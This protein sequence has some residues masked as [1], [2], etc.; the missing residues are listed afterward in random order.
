MEFNRSMMTVDEAGICS[1]DEI[2][3]RFSDD[4][5]FSINLPSHVAS[6]LD[7]D[8]RVSGDTIVK[9][10]ELYEDKCDQYSKQRLS[11]VSTPMLLITGNWHYTFGKQG[12]G[13]ELGWMPVMQFVSPDGE[14]HVMTVRN[15]GTL[16]ETWN[17][18][19]PGRL[20]DDTPEHREKIQALVD[21]IKTAHAMLTDFNACSNPAE[22]LMAIGDD[23]TPRH[24]G[25]VVSSPDQLGLFGNKPGEQT[26]EVKVTPQDTVVEGAKAVDAA[27][28]QAAADGQKKPRGKAAKPAAPPPVAPAATDYEEF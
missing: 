27:L 2:L 22:F 16:G 11:A 12:S 19:F 9:T 28:E 7:I 14:M 25:G 24:S 10:V 4:D 13:V 23:W 15:D 17:D 3:V 8:C 26:V 20:I 5:L 18:P 6:F 21:S 1:T